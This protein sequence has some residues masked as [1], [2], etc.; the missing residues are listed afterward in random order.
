MSFLTSSGLVSYINSLNTAVP[1][2]LGQPVA[3][4]QAIGA[5]YTNIDV[6]LTPKGTGAILG[7]VP[8]NT[9]AGGNKRGF[10]SVDWQVQRTLATQV[11]SGANAVIAG[12]R[13]NLCSVDYGTVSGGLENNV[14]GGQNGTIG[15]GS[16]NTVDAINGTIPGGSAGWTRGVKGALAYGG[17][18]I[19]SV[20]S[21]GFF[22]YRDIVYRTVTNDATATPFTSDN[23]GAAQ[24]N[25]CA[26]MSAKQAASFIG[27][28][29]A[30]GNLTDDTHAW[31]VSG[32]IKRPGAA[33]TTVLVAST[34][35]DLGSDAGAAAWTVALSADVGVGGLRV[36]ITGAA[37]TAIS[38]SGHIRFAEVMHV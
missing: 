18:G 2:N 6:S 19:G 33:A 31:Q 26:V 38:W 37:G 4:F 35:T 3:S 8:D 1:N 27:Q 10:A 7:S 11:A 9:P 28:I 21:L 14:T 5:A 16:T 13:S 24:A 29:V 23:S 34:V 25:N 12:G 20:A 30:V 17:N 22:Q 32:L 36:T 15:G